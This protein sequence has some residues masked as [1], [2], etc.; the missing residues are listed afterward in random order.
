VDPDLD[1]LSYGWRTVCQPEGA[2]V[3]LHQAEERV[4]AAAG[5][6]LAGDYVFEVQVSDGASTVSRQVLVRA[7]DGNQPPVPMDVHNRIPVWVTTR[8]AHTLLRAGAWDV[9]DDAL[10]FHWSVA[11]APRGAVPV[12]EMPDEPACRATGLIVPG[13]YVFRL[14]LSDQDHTVAVEHTVPV[15]P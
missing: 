4:A 2:R 15:Y 3:E 8:D 5:M 9:E 6:T 10:A 7:F 11:A 1:G 14:E 13:D 12:L